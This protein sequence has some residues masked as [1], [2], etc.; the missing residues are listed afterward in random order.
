MQDAS[1]LRGLETYDGYSPNLFWAET[2]VC[3]ILLQAPGFQSKE[4]FHAD[5]EWWRSLENPLDDWAYCKAAFPSVHHRYW[6]PNVSESQ[7]TGMSWHQIWKKNAYQKGGLRVQIHIL[8][9]L[10]SAW[11]LHLKKLTYE[12]HTFNNT[13]NQLPMRL[14]KVH[15]PL[16]KPGHNLMRKIFP[17]LLNWKTCCLNYP[18]P[19]C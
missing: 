14:Y 4:T 8:S 1:R 15:P 17:D 5:P 18:L 16:P 10:S 6:V 2:P 13:S 12:R 3:L 9:L 7:L 11:F 19:H